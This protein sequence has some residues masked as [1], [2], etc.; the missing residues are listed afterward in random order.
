MVKRDDTD[1]SDDSD[2]DQ[3]TLNRLREAVDS[4]TLKDKFYANDSED[5]VISR[6]ES[7]DRIPGPGDTPRLQ[8][9]CNTQSDV[10]NDTEDPRKLSDTLKRIVEKNRSLSKKKVST[11]EGKLK[12][13]RRDKQTE[14]S[15]P[16]V[17]SELDVTPQFQKFV[18]S[19]LDEF[20][21]SQIK[22]VV[23]NNDVSQ[24]TVNGHNDTG[25]KL[26]KRSKNAVKNYE[27]INLSGKRHKPDLLAHTKVE[28][29]EEDLNSCAVSGEFVLSKVDTE[30]WVNKFP[31]RV[32]E[33]I[34]RIKKK[35]KKV[36]KSKKKKTVTE[37]ANVIQE[38]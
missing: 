13:L 5:K 11:E 2:E 21:D 20:L 25:P 31:D 4:E 10:D 38:T 23:K 8:T 28:T 3:E 22:D 18:G 9:D 37:E 29:S 15:K 7:P 27:D 35:K 26:L 33:G 34:A 32:E 16:S 12:S 6:E 24:K 36:K 30:A 1:N 17:I 14:D 19:K